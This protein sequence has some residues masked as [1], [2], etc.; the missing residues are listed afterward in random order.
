MIIQRKQRARKLDYSPV[1]IDAFDLISQLPKY[2][3]QHILFFMPPK[4][5]ARTSVSSKTWR[6]AWISL[7][8]CDFS[9][10]L[11]CLSRQHY[12]TEEFVNR[13]DEA[14]VILKEQKILVREFKLR[15]K[16]RDTIDASCIDNWMQL[17][18]KNHIKKL[19]LGIEGQEN[20]KSYTLPRTIFEEMDVYPSEWKGVQKLLSCCPSLEAL[21]VDT[22][23][24][25]YIGR[26]KSSLQLVNVPKLKKAYLR[27]VQKIRI[28]AP[29]LRT[30]YCEGWIRAKLDL[31]L[32]AYLAV[33]FNSKD[34]DVSIHRLKRYEVDLNEESIPPRPNI[35]HLMLS[36]VPILEDYTALIDGLL[37][38]C[39]PK[40][41]S[42]HSNP[43]SKFIKPL[44]ETLMGREEKPK[45]CSGL[46]TKCWRHYLKAVKL[47]NHS[48][49]LA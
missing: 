8:M 44:Y 22:S 3:I 33:L 20:I 40:I 29:A 10:V 48:G 41:L 39:H 28:E 49:C 19:D 43:E 30:L 32:I 6:R 11:F 26:C 13:V 15:M 46:N 47:I 31:N 25:S 16:V 2:I 36:N 37:W 23:P 18:M 12:E 5:T 9:C 17:L 1:S 4:D 27:N 7:P 34:I 45:C 35:K 42:A 21:T 38:S 14:L 24:R